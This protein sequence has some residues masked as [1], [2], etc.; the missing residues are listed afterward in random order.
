MVKHYLS[1]DWINRVGLVDSSRA[2]PWI[3]RFVAGDES[4]RFKVWALLVLHAWLGSRS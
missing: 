4:L 3:E 1:A 2:T